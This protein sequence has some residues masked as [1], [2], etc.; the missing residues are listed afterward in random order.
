MA[1][2]SILIQTVPTL[3]KLGNHISPVHRPSFFSSIIVP[4]MSKIRAE[5]EKKINVMVRGSC[6]FPSHAIL[7]KKIGCGWV[8]L[9]SQI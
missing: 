3:K 9:V 2:G 7:T 8:I 1:R 5:S 6:S 4:C